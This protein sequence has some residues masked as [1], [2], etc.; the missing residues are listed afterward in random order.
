MRPICDPTWAGYHFQS[1]DISDTAINQDKGLIKMTNEDN[2]CVILH[3]NI[4]AKT[5]WM[6]PKEPSESKELSH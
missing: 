3:Q 2:F 1:K 5:C 6:H 4:S